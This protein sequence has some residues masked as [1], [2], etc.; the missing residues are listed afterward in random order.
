MWHQQGELIFAIGRACLVG[1]LINPAYGKAKPVTTRQPCRRYM[2]D[3]SPV[4]VGTRQEKHFASV[5]F[6]E[7]RRCAQQSIKNHINQQNK[8]Y[9]PS[10]ADENYDLYTLA[11][12]DEIFFISWGLG[13]TAAVVH[14]S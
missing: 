6:I 14:T 8:K 1:K 7:G 9:C 4:R 10:K 3:K 11:H 2:V 5:R 13:L 12:A